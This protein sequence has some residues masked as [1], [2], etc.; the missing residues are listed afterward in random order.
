MKNIIDLS[1]V[2]PGCRVTFVMNHGTDAMDKKMNVGGRERSNPLLGRVTR[3]IHMAG[4]AAGAETYAN[5]AERKDVEIAGKPSNWNNHP[6]FPCIVT[7]KSNPEKMAVRV[8]SAKRQAS[9]LFVDGRPATPEEMTTFAQYKKSSGENEL[10]YM[11]LGVEH[12]ANCE[13]PE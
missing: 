1:N 9:H 4:N 2:K 8:I 13:L 11:T 10:G 7:L 5:V 6:T 3:T 12:L